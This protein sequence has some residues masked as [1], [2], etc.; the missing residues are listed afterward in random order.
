MHKTAGLP[1]LLRSKLWAISY[2]LFTALVYQRTSMSVRVHH[3]TMEDVAMES[4]VTDAHVMMATR[5]HSVMVNIWY[6]KPIILNYV[7]NWKTN[8]IKLYIAPRKN[9]H[10]IV[11][12]HFSKVIQILYIPEYNIAKQ[13]PLN[14]V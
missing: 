3:A 11:N 12:R 14:I 6:L 2:Y 1:W 5:A 9:S 10:Q 13:H 7:R 8:V 4:I